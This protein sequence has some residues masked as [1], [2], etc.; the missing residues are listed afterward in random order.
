VAPDR[1]RFDFTHP[2][3]LTSEETERIEQIVNDEILGNHRLAI[4]EKPR[5]QAVAE[6][7]M[8]LFG[9]TYGETVRTVGIGAPER[10]SYELCG[11]TH[12]PETGVIGLF[13][14]VSEASVA[15]GVRRIEALTGRGALALIQERLKIL[16]R[17]AARLGTAP[18][19]V[20][21]RLRSLDKEREQIARELARQ[22]ERLALV[23]YE[24]LEIENISGISLLAGVIPEA[25]A[26]SLRRLTD[27]FRQDHPSGVIVLGA[28]ENGRPLIIAAVSQDL[29]GRGLHAGEIVRAAAQ[30]VGG[31]GGGKPML[32]QAGGKDASR[33]PEALSIAREWVRSHV[34]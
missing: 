3:A 26:D 27:R 19:A 34:K 30:A 29:I 18:E 22:R 6:G 13:V 11:G 8:A 16:E 24:R 28:V 2:E 21:D 20:E 12:V 9:E 33:L 17:V 25:D 1:L 7:A 5:E 32:A 10:F 15:A 4:L 23:A 14:I 31:G